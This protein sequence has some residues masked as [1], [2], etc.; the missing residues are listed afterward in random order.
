MESSK[1]LIESM[2]PACAMASEA[3]EKLTG[4]I[5]ET[6]EQMAWM[7]TVAEQI[8]RDVEGPQR[9]LSAIDGELK[10][11]DE[12]RAAAERLTISLNGIAQQSM[13]ERLAATRVQRELMRR[14]RHRQPLDLEDES[15]APT[16]IRVAALA[17]STADAPSF[18]LPDL[19]DDERAELIERSLQLPPRHQQPTNVF[20]MVAAG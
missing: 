2:E 19:A 17:K 14:H 20:E 15:D 11:L 12:A 4:T 5:A 7:R 13:E 6:N 18:D 10:R 16:P 8:R 1:E 3:A 9:C